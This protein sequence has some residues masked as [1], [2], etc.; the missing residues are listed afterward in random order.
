EIT[1][2][3]RAT[4]PRDAFIHGERTVENFN[5][6]TGVMDSVTESYA[7][8]PAPVVDYLGMTIF[9]DRISTRILEHTRLFADKT[10]EIDPA[11]RKETS[12]FHVLCAATVKAKI[13]GKYGQCQVHQAADVSFGKVL[14]GTDPTPAFRMAMKV[15]ITDAR[16]TALQLFVPVFGGI[17]T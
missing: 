4:L 11:T 8:V 12:D 17:D 15:A 2:R 10:L 16:R 1:T 7:Y 13:T 14:L 6:N 5:P 3:L 9:K